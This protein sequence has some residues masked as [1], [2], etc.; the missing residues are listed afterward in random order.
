MDWCRFRRAGRIADLGDVR[1]WYDD[2][3]GGDPLVLVGGFGA[4]HFIWDF[5]WPLLPEFRR[6]TLEPRGLGRSERHASAI[7]LELGDAG[8]LD[9]AWAGP[10]TLRPSSEDT[11][12]EGSSPGSRARLAAAPGG[13]PEAAFTVSNLRRVRSR[14]AE[15]ALSTR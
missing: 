4:G 9:R 6:V 8:I 15:I 13:L 11:R 7:A 2:E 1:L 10:A 5:V 3:E 14:R 12:S